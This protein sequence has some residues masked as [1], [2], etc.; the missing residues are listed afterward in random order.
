VQLRAQRFGL[1]G[2]EPDAPNLLVD[3]GSLTVSSLFKEDWFQFGFYGGA[4]VYRLV[5]RDLEPGQTAA[6]VKES[7]FGWTGALVTIFD[8]GP[9]WDLRVEGAGHLIRTNVSHT[10]ILITAGIGYRF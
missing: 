2:T 9:R 6:D 10:P 4:G 7:A 1:P 8:L 5:P 3:A